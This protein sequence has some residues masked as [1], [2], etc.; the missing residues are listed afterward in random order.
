MSNDPAIEQ[1]LADLSSAD[2]ASRRAALQR[3]RSHQDDSIA[4]KVVPL[5]KDGDSTVRRLAAE[6]LSRNVSAS[7]VHALIDTLYD[8]QAD[9]RAAAADALGQSGE[10]AAVPALFDA[11]YD[12]DGDVRFAAAEALG[13]LGDPRAVLDLIRLLDGDDYPLA[14]MAG[15]ALLRIGTPEALAAIQHLKE[16]EGYNF[17][18]PADLET[19]PPPLASA[20]APAQAE[21]SDA[22]LRG[23]PS[24]LLGEHLGEQNAP[25]AAS[26]QDDVELTPALFSAYAPRETAPNVWQPLRAY[27]Y[28][29]SSATDVAID[30]AAEL[31]GLL[32]NYRRVER[33]ASGQIA[34]GALI[35][36]TPSIPGFQFNPPSAQVAFYDDFERFDFKLRA[37]DAPLDQAGNGGITFTV[38]GVIIADVPLSVYVGTASPDSSGVPTHVSRPVYQS[39][40]CSYSRQDSQIV[41]HIERAYKALGLTFLRDVE[42]LRSGEDWEQRLPQLIA[43]ADIFQLFW[44]QAAADSQAVRKE[45]TYALTLKRQDSAFIRPV[46]WQQPMPP[47][48]P[49]LAPINFAYEPD[50]SQP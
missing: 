14:M 23:I 7:A 5:L 47:P 8:P 33:P 4:P 40:F 24:D 46:Y 6:V 43:Q 35:V 28:K 1:A 38:A 15:R 36:A 34:E 27:V 29:P 17:E 37:V 30:A 31:G 42:T 49:E 26:A 16:G 13:L 32:P 39:I 50:L 44:S 9:V 10:R 25:G 2:L 48:P 20:P 11:L 21:D 22:T 19:T 18:L 12:E 45:W 3:L 41:E